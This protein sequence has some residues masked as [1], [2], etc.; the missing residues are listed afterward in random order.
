MSI[1]SGGYNS[2]PT[3][4]LETFEIQDTDMHLFTDASKSLCECGSLEINRWNIIRV[5]I[6]KVDFGGFFVDYG[7]EDIAKK[8]CSPFAA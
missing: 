6:S 5:F 4:A 7:R 1:S 8:A 2:S 3:G